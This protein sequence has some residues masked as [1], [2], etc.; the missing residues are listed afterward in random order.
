MIRPLPVDRGQITLS[1][2]LWFWLKI[3]ICGTGSKECSCIVCGSITVDPLCCRWVFRPWVCGCRTTTFVSLQQ[4][5]TQCHSSFWMQAKR[6]S[7]RTPPPS[8]C[9]VNIGQAVQLEINSMPFY[10]GKKLTVELIDKVMLCSCF[11]P[12][13]PSVAIWV[14]L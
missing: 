8:V 10:C 12:L 5:L 6:H 2:W 9:T 13:T 1:V 3:T 11:N 4:S 14:Q 7:Q